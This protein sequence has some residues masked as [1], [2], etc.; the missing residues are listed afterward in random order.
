YFGAA[1]VLIGIAM[2]VIRR[3]QHAPQSVTEE[4][5]LARAVADAKDDD[6]FA[7][8]EFF[9]DDVLDDDVDEPD[10]EAHDEPLE[11]PLEEPDAAPKKPDGSA[12]AETEASPSA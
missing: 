7:D 2:L 1:F 4:M 9:D 11:E 12:A 8:D 6:P 5:V 10:E 3:R